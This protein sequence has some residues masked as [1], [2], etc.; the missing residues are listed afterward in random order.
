MADFRQYELIFT[1]TETFDE[2]KATGEQIASMNQSSPWWCGDYFNQVMERFP[3]RSQVIASNNKWMAFAET[4]SAYAPDER[5]RGVSFDIHAY[6]KDKEDRH[7]QLILAHQE[8]HSLKDVRDRNSDQ[9]THDLG[10][11]KRLSRKHLNMIGEMTKLSGV[12]LAIDEHGFQFES[13]KD[14]ELAEEAIKLAIR[15]ALEQR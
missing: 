7:K 10:R 9:I 2:L 13:I 5:I 12:T 8:G 15:K 1:G 4:A 3:E 6:L 14:A 11:G